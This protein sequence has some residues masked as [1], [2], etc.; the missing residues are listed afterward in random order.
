MQRRRKN[1]VNPADPNRA[2]RHRERRGLWVPRR[3]QIRRPRAAAAGTPRSAA[4]ATP[5]SA[6]TVR[7]LA[8]IRA[9][10][11]RRVAAAGPARR[12]AAA[13]GR[14]RALPRRASS[15]PR[16]AC[17][18]STGSCAPGLTCSPQTLP[19][20]NLCCTGTNCAPTGGSIGS[21]CGPVPGAALCTPGITVPPATAGNDSC[22][23]PTSSFVESTTLCAIGAA[24]GGSQPAIVEVFYN[25]EH[26]LTLGCAT[27]SYPVS[28]LSSDPNAV[29]Y[30]Q[31]GDPGC[32]DTVGRPLRPVLFVTDITSD[33]S[34]NAGDLQQGGH[35]YDPVAIFGSWKSATEGDGGVGTPAMMDPMSNKWT[36]GPG[37]TRTVADQ[38]LHRRLRNG[39]A[40]RGGAHFRPLGI[41]CKSS[42]TT[43]TRTR[44]AIR[45]R[46]AP[47][48]APGVARSARR[49]VPSA[50][51][52][53][54]ARV[55]REQS[56]R[57]DAACHRAQGRTTT[58]GAATIAGAAGAAAGSNSFRERREGGRAAS[59]RRP[60]RR[61]GWLPETRRGTMPN[62]RPLGLWPTHSL[63]RA[64]P[65]SDGERETHAG[66]GVDDELTAPLGARR[67]CALAR[68]LA[69]WE[70]VEERRRRRASPGG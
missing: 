22:G 66:R 45:A 7:R 28:P 21:T 35:P 67:A 5:R 49:A 50:G 19:R 44:A 8:R 4:A 69:G 34:C 56:A 6:R 61:P 42:S 48:S 10:E 1:L 32:T 29:H 58:A 37:W 9:A 36:L 13:V 15:G 55:P 53:T 23:Y 16:D 26:A 25:D 33:P 68:E 30:P 52:P 20:P 57:R 27:A 2:C 3:M 62:G 11:A 31:T 17:A 39:A 43:A 18:D 63:R 64:D 14:P 12:V 54:P 40:L 46:V 70:M 65:R 24:G 41:V 38:D 51:W 60:A 47:S 59:R